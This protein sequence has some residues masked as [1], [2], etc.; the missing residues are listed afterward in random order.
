MPLH[1]TPEQKQIGK[2]NF[3][4]AVGLNRRSFLKGAAAATAGLG[5]T[6]FAYDKLK[7]APVRVGWIG[8]GD[9]GSV[10]L[11]QHPPEYMDIVAIAD[12]RPS[13]RERAFIGDGNEHRVGLIKK[14]GE[15]KCKKIKRYEIGRAH[16]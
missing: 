7:G 16:V 1:L 3:N 11:T 10:L 14:L 2:D 13:N 4:E 6:Y 5:A 9:E 15:A 12:L 8:C